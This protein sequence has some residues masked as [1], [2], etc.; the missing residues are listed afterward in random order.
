M[1]SCPYISHQRES[2]EANRKGLLCCKGWLVYVASLLDCLCLRAQKETGSMHSLTQLH[3][4]TAFRTQDSTNLYT[5]TQPYMKFEEWRR[6]F[7]QWLAFALPST[8][9]KKGGH[10]LW[11]QARMAWFVVPGRDV[12]V[13]VC[14][15]YTPC[16]C[17]NL[18]FLFSVNISRLY[19]TE[20]IKRHE[21]SPYTLTSLCQPTQVNVYLPLPPS[22]YLMARQPQLSQAVQ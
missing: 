16:S 20:E 18:H 1:L 17:T 13:C 2:K 5:Q 8:S 19:V 3:P 15:Q 12:C 11:M 7:L 22:W 14:T 4:P 10:S 21:V 6:P 9:R